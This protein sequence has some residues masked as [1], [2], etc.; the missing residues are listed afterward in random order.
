MIRED[1]GGAP[2]EE[3]ARKWPQSMGV[4]KIPSMFD[5][6]VEKSAEELSPSLLEVTTIA[7]DIVAGNA[8]K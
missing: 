4:M 8:D 7:D 3:D 6:V 1:S 5:S 2:L